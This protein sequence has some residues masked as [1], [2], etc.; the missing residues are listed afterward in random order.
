MIFSVEIDASNKC[1]QKSMKYLVYE[2]Y[3][4]SL[5]RG[6]GQGHGGTKQSENLRNRQIDIYLFYKM[7]KNK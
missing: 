1:K 5:K 6:G 3:T 4:W 2:V 7:M